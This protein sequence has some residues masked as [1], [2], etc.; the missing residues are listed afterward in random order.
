MT[1]AEIKYM[2]IMYIYVTGVLDKVPNTFFFFT[3]TKPKKKNGICGRPSHPLPWSHSSLLH[4]RVA[5][6]LRGR[7]NCSVLVV[8][9]FGTIH[10]GIKL[11][12]WERRGKSVVKG[13]I[14]FKNYY[15]Y[16]FQTWTD[17]DTYNRSAF[18]SW[19]VNVST[20]YP[21]SIHTSSIVCF[22]VSMWGG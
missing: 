6:S 15:Y 13:W 16:Y 2:F 19:T 17:I 20:L 1:S 9:Q 21:D 3:K 14:L 18:L 12:V 7:L 4:R 10:P 5:A 8:G 22:K 11:T